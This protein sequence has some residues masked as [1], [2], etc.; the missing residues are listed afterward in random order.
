MD[1]VNNA[2]ISDFKD[3]KELVESLK[4]LIVKEEIDEEVKEEVNSEKPN[5]IRIKN[6]LGKIPQGIATEIVMATQGIALYE[7][8]KPSIEK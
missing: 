8:L 3:I 5:H 1:Y 4:N 6:F 7:K 2:T